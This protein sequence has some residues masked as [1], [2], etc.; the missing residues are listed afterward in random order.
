MG[1]YFI[2]LKFDNFLM[3]RKNSC[4]F[5]KENYLSRNLTHIRTWY[6]IIIVNPK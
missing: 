2:L 1:Y 4:I 6:M 3:S 5:I